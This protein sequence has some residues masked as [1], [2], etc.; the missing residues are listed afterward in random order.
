HD[1]AE[2]LALGGREDGIEHRDRTPVREEM[3]LLVPC[4][5]LAAEVELVVDTPGKDKV[6][7]AGRLDA[8]SLETRDGVLTFL[9]L[10]AERAEEAAGLGRWVAGATICFPDV[11]VAAPV[12]QERTTEN[13]VDALCKEVSA[14]KL[15]ASSCSLEVSCDVE[16]G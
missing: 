1:V 10:S 15:R 14:R 4:P 2:A 5:G 16:L 7:R 6:V 13:V 12:G 11:A 3:T 8:C 9:E